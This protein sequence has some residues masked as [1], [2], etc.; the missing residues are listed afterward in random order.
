MKAVAQVQN[1][2]KLLLSTDPSRLQDYTSDFWHHNSL[3]DEVQRASA[4]TP[5]QYNILVRNPIAPVIAPFL[6]VA[7]L[8]HDPIGLS[9]RFLCAANGYLHAERTAKSLPLQAAELW[10]RSFCPRQR[11]PDVEPLASNLSIRNTTAM[12]CYVTSWFV[13][14]QLHSPS[15]KTSVPVT[16]D[17]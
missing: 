13:Y 15:V 16:T 3:H 2:Q 9:T 8:L 6:Y 7:E 17:V 4:S 11:A 1:W 12:K 14:T 5:Q 10:L